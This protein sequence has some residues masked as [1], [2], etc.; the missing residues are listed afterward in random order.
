[1]T[2]V[3]IDRLAAYLGLTTQ[4][5]IDQF[6]HLARDRSG[7]VL[8]DQADGGC[9]FLIE[10]RCRVNSAKPSQC[11]NFPTAWNNPGWETSCQAHR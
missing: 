2:D 4:A 11:A 1:V 9:I 8:S 7:L 3:D 6:T 5:F 10:N